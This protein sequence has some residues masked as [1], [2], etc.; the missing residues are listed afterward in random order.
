MLTIETEVSYSVKQIPTRA[1]FAGTP[2][3]VNHGIRLTVESGTSDPD[4][5][6]RF[7]F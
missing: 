7:A 2:P 6:P 4:L 5:F 3:E 1:N